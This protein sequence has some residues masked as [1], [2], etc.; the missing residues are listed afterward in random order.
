MIRV[1]LTE[2][3]AVCLSRLL[4]SIEANATVEEQARESFAAL[5]AAAGKLRDGLREARP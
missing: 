5:E 3:E 4:A 1:E 2:Y